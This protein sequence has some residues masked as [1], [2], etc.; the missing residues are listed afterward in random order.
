MKVKEAQKSGVT[1]RTTKSFVR[2]EFLPFLI[3]VLLIYQKYSDDTKKLVKDVT[4]NKWGYRGL[5]KFTPESDTDYLFGLINQ[6]YESTLQE[7]FTTL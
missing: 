4:S 2:F 1:Y 3:Q 6:S 7:I 5:V